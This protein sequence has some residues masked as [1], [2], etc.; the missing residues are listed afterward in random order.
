MNGRSSLYVCESTVTCRSSI[1]SSNADCVLG[2]ARLISSAST[3]LANTPPGRNSKSLRVAVP[4]RHAGDVGGQEV[5]GELHAAPRTTD[6]TRDRLGERGLADA[7]NVFDQQVTFGEQADERE[8]NG[9]AL[10]AQHA[11]ELCRQRVEQILER[12]LRSGGG[13]HQI[14]LRRGRGTSTSPSN[15]ERPPTPGT[16]TAG[17]TL[18]CRDVG[19]TRTDGRM[20]HGRAI[21]FPL[22][23]AVVARPRPL[24]HGAPSTGPH[25]SVGLVA[26]GPVPSAARRQLPAVP[27]RD[28]V[29]D[30][31]ERR[32]RGDVEAYLAWCRA[33]DRTLHTSHARRL[34]RF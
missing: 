20:T 29:R 30:R 22:F 31:R 34:Q 3:T 12:L 26:A 27:H 17:A 21:W 14:D 5:G 9:A 23:L 7:G 32:P 11:F 19:T 6:R 2:D 18:P 4:D 33:S 10:P 15:S 8:V 1:A 13:L 24:A 25:D 16:A 28:R